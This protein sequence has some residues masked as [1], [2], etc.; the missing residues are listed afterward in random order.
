VKAVVLGAGVCGLSCA[1]RLLAHGFEVEIWAREHQLATTSTVAGAIWYPFHA[2][3]IERVRGWAFD[4]LDRYGEFARDARSGVVFRTGCE[5]FRPGVEPQAWINELPALRELGARELPRG[6]ARGIE[7]Q[8]PVVETPVHMAWLERRVAELGA[9]ICARSVLAFEEAFESAPLVVDATGL[10]ARAL[11]QDSDLH[12]VGGQI[13]RVEQEGFERFWFDFSGE[14]PT[15]VIPRAHDVVL[16]GSLEAED[17]NEASRQAALEGIRA[18]C[19]I[20]EPRLANA[21]ELGTTRGLRPV[22]SVVRLEAESPRPGRLLVHDYG[23][24]G[25][26]IT[27]AWGCA[28]EVVGIARKWR[29]EG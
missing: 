5:V 8:A 22:R 7:F 15:Y 10:G 6:S 24:G 14:Q 11:A 28:E 17:A 19:R 27:L 23:H 20:L 12:P 26:G 16:G 9:Q 29:D 21:R 3:P 25:A 18:R 1:E 2:N 13:V 4:S